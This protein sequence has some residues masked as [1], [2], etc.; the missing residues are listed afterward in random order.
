M[1]NSA[2]GWD[3]ESHHCDGRICQSPAYATVRQAVGQGGGEP[4]G[5]EAV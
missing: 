2:N 4:F 3:S 5:S 1:L